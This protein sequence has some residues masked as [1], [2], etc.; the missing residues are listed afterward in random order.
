MAR[1]FT[2]H[3]GSS[4]LPSGRAGRRYF[5]ISSLVTRC[6]GR[7]EPTPRTDTDTSDANAGIIE[8][9]IG[10]PPPCLTGG[11]S[12]PPTHLQWR[13][14]AAERVEAKVQ[15]LDPA[16]SCNWVEPSPGGA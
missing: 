11:C 6:S 8:P 3:S 2:T 1:C 5:R 16:E 9:V 4:N 7:Y 13:A 10:T 14:A 15:D 12:L